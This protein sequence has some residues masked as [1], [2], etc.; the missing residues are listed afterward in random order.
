METYTIEA[1]EKIM[2]E[3][4]SGDESKDELPL[5]RGEFKEILYNLTT[6]TSE[7]MLALCSRIEILE[8]ICG[9]FMHDNDETV[10]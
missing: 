2:N 8:R 5:T 9:D 10:H 3:I 1:L 6:D 7:C 4:D